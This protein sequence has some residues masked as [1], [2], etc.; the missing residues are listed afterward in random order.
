MITLKRVV[1][2][3]TVQLETYEMDVRPKDILA[4]HDGL[5]V[6]GSHQFNVVETKD[7]IHAKITESGDI[8]A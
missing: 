2:K 6:I 7:E 5:V 4:F 3:S 8:W 1:H